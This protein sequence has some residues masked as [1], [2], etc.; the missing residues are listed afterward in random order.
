[1]KT[2][3]LKQTDESW[4]SQRA[5]GRYHP[6]AVV[7]WRGV[8]RVLSAGDSDWVHFFEEDG[9]LFALTVNHRM[10]YCGLEVF[11]EDD[12][13]AA[14]SVFAQ[15]EEELR[16]VVGP[17]GLDYAPMTLARRLADYALAC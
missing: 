17:R 4:E 1:M 16:E 11:Q 9:A 15:S 8:E 12:R 2:I 7:T 3:T 14:G 10:G 5:A 6:A 13:E